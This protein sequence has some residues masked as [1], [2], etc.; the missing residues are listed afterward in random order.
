MDRGLERDEQDT[1]RRDI[2]GFYITNADGSEDYRLPPWSETMWEDTQANNPFL[3]S[4]TARAALTVWQDLNGKAPAQVNRIVLRLPALIPGMLSLVALWWWLRLMGLTLS[5]N[6]ALLLGALHPMHVDYS[7]QARGYAYVM[8]FTALA[9]GLGWLALTQGRWRHWAGLAACFLG[10]LCANPGSIYFCASMGTS[11]GIYLTVRLIRY[12]DIDARAGLVRFIICNVFAAA[13]YL[14]L[15]LP[16]LPQ[17]L[18]YLKTFKG[19]LD[20]PWP[21]QTL[22]KYFAGVMMPAATDYYMAVN[23]ELSTWEFFMRDYVRSERLL[24]LVVFLIVPSLIV[25]GVSRLVSVDR[26]AWP[27]IIAGLG[28]PLCAYV[29]HR[30]ADT[31]YLYYWYLIYA[32]PVVIALVGA[33]LERCGESAQ[34]WLHA[35]WARALPAT[36]FLLLMAVTS[37]GGPGRM[38]WFPSP[39]VGDVAFERGKYVWITGQDGRT[40]RV[41]VTKP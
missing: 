34:E 36:L 13:I 6:I 17:A 22:S 9:L 27:L 3:F 28:A 12:R 32:L 38:V 23:D 4:I 35:G 33:G 24:L 40:K 31:T 19:A 20:G 26:K 15:V 30:P 2:L 1:V 16:A 18:G 29:Y 41:P 25:C 5:A 10:S 7:T 14:P 11:I 8:M 21:L 37:V 39:Q